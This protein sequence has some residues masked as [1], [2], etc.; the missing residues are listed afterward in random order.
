M[1]TP[2]RA[3]KEARDMAILNEWNEL[4]SVPGQSRTMVRDMLMKKYGLNAPSALYAALHRAEKL[5]AGGE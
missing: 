3:K 2:Y 4:V 1:K 5:M